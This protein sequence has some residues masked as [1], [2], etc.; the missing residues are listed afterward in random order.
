MTHESKAGQYL[1]FAL[2]DALFGVPATQVESAVAP[3]AVTPLPFVPAFVEGLVSVNDRVV[4]LLDLRALLSAQA[5]PV[6]GELV[7]VD[8]ARAPCAW[9]VDRVVASVLPEAV[10]GAA[11]DAGAEQAAGYVRERFTHEGRTVL[12]L[13]ADALA[14]LVS[15][16]A[17][18]AGRRGLLGADEQPAAESAATQQSGIRVRCGNESYAVALAD[19]L[20]ILDLPAAVPVP[21]AP[22]V[23][24][25]LALVRGDVLLVLSL[26][27][28]LGRAA[29]GGARSV[30]VVTHDGYRY[31][32]RVD[33][34][35]GILA[36]DAGAWRGIDED[37]GD[38]A[39]VVVAG[40]R[41]IGLVTAQRLFTA[42]RRRAL[43][44]YLPARS[45]DREAVSEPVQSV[46]EVTLAGERLGIPLPV[47]RRIAGRQLQRGR[48]DAGGNSAS[49]SQSLVNL[50]G[51][52]LPVLDLSVVLGSTEAD[53][54]ERQGAWIVV[55]DDAREWALP[56]QQAR[57]IVEVPLS[58]VESIGHEPGAL[59]Q[60]VAR[61]D[62]G[63]MSLLTLAPLLEAA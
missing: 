40:D 8:S 26:A 58:A 33:A 3:R 1:V 55:G 60:S 51:V 57:R 59:V 21:G 7:I 35:E 25:G 24:E 34:V 63:L 19:A 39:G 41:A 56:V 53:G 48:D 23:V 46:L 10:A 4:P 31:G 2:G 6:R 14:A 28:L 44:P 27:A 54:S 61:V 18:P 5:P 12:V 47:V 43:A 15:A 50:D 52:V 36:W 17:L 22:A 16:Q 30:L 38:L 29:D 45:D 42:T 9:R 20:E 13:D 11:G 37:G 49:A 62:A 32:L